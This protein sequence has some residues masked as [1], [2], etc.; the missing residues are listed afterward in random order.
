MSF[1]VS[2]KLC[3]ACSTLNEAN[4]EV[5]VFD[6]LPAIDRV[7]GLMA[8][9]DVA[10]WIVMGV[11]LDDARLLTPSAVAVHTPQDRD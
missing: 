2:C 6:S 8:C 5:V 4:D 9:V 1:L 11:T 3:T 10:V 7:S